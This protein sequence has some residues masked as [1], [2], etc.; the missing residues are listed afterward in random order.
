[1][2][3][4]LIK[5]YNKRCGTLIEPFCLSFG[6]EDRSDIGEGVDKG[7]EDAED[8]DQQKP[9]KEVLK[10]PFTRQIIEFSA[11]KHRR[12]LTGDCRDYSRSSALYSGSGEEA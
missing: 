12:G 4:A 8:E 6:D 11:P 1:M 3:S 7:A 10:S 9:Y 5:Q 2:S